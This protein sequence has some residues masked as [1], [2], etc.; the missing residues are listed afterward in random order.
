MRFSPDQLRDLASSMQGLAIDL[1]DGPGNHGDGMCVEAAQ[2]L[3]FAARK[4]EMLEH[5]A[6]CLL[7]GDA[8]QV[9]A[10]MCEDEGLAALAKDLTRAGT[11]G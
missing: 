4:I 7:D 9:M 2:A 5:F 6:R 3:R 8:N 11:S 1:K 10:M